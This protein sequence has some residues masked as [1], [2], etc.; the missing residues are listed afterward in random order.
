[1]RRERRQSGA[2]G[3]CRVLVVEDEALIAL[4]LED[5]LEELGCHLVGI[6]ASVGEG[7]ALAASAVA[8][9]AVLDVN[10]GGTDVYPVAERLA[11][12][13]I[14]FVFSTG[15]GA[16]GLPERWRGRPVVGKPFMLDD[17]RRALRAALAPG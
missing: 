13:G 14:P 6:A 12:R 8:D 1:M 9:V 16:E 3:R 17:L 4:L 5:M 10:V 2:D 11:A 7:L 15:Y